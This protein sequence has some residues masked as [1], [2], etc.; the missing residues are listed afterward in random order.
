MKS[1]A[2]RN[3]LAIGAVG[4][5][6]T[7]AAVLIGLQYKNLPFVNSDKEYSAYFA[8]AGGLTSGAPVQVSGYQVGSVSSVKLDGARVVV[9]F[10][11]DKG[12]QLGDRTEASIKTKSLLGSKILEVTPRGDASLSGPIPIDRTTPPYQLADALGD[13]A[14][15]IDQLDTGQLSQSLATLA[16]T[17]ANTPPDLQVAVQGLA[18]FSQSLNQRDTQLR[19]LL[20][21]ANKT[22]KVLADRSDQ[23]VNL[24]AQTNALLAQLRS[25]SNALDNVSGNVSRLSRQLSGFVAD[26]RQQ[27]RPAVDKLNG[28]LTIVA[29]RKD[30]VQDSIKRL[31]SYAMSLGESVSSGPFF[32]SYLANLLPGQ[33]LQP[34]I[35]AAFSDLGLDPNVL[36]PSQLTDPQTGQ[37]GTPALPVPFPRTGQGGEPKL[38]LPD[39]ITGNPGDPRYPYREPLPAPPLGGPPPGPPAPIKPE[40]GTP[41]TEPTPSPVYQPAP[42]EVP[43]PGA[44][45]P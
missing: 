11:L 26:N 9:D 35:D 2:E 44:V 28:V 23:V 42:G 41:Q 43:Q 38:T 7:A 31:D 3:P 14:T 13:L 1:F 45:V 12:V 5:A 4:V 27:F 18:R 24:I 17:F 16:Q 29:N 36:A 22:T 10:E 21:N 32:N 6:L 34:F 25:E 37:P 39:A 20:A 33:F 30:R 19:N 15:T 8:E 40:P